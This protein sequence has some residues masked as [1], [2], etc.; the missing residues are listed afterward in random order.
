[1]YSISADR[2]NSASTA[3]IVR[4]VYIHSLE[5]TDDYTWEGINLVKWSIIEPAIALTAAAFATLRPLFQKF[6]PSKPTILPPVKTGT[7]TSSSNASKENLDGKGQRYSGDSYTSEFAQML[8]LCRTGVTTTIYADKQKKRSIWDRK[9]VEG[10]R[11]PKSPMWGSRE[12]P[13]E[14]MTEL[15][16]MEGVFGGEDKKVDRGMGIRTTTVVTRTVG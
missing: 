14:S 3:T 1:M 7:Q 16:D 12:K 5:S 13:S 11:S 4:I 9:E 6:F 8:G 10:L 2:W 15:N